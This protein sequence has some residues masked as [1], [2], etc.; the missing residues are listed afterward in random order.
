MKSLQIAQLNN[1]DEI[2][3]FPNVKGIQK[4]IALS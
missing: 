2:F 3:S 1:I 4:K